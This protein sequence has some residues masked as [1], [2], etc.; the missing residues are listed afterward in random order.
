MKT[1]LSKYL[2]G[3]IIIVVIIVTLL[4]T[5]R[6]TLPVLATVQANSLYLKSGPSELF[7]R[8][9]LY[10]KWSIVTVL[11]IV[12]GEQWVYVETSDEQIGWMSTDYLWIIGEPSSLPEL[13][14]TNG[15]QLSG[16]VTDFQD[17]P[18][19]GVMLAIRENDTNSNERI[20]VRTNSEGKFHAFIPEG[21]TRYWDV[22]VV[23][24]DCNNHLVDVNCEL[25]GYYLKPAQMKV[26]L[27]Q[28][29]P[30]AFVYE[31]GS[32][33][34]QGTV[35]N[36]QGTPTGNIRVIA[37]RSDG[38]KTWGLVSKA[39]TFALAVSEGQWEVYALKAEQVGTIVSV[40]IDKD[41]LATSIVIPAP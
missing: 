30:L 18:V 23:G 20:T 14:I 40:D 13:E 4:Y 38:A 15:L 26:D 33:N 25:A 10:P 36:N 11:G 1:K 39:G 22:S 29:E 37:Q 41:G 19:T 5:F 2:V 16:T 3:S 7:E 24:H 32:T 17:T 28:D 9:G 34:L 27:A 12:P 8:V 21:K 35:L 31:A 6:S